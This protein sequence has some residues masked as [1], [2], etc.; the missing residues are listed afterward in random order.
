MTRGLPASLAALPV[1]LALAVPLGLVVGARV[2]AL[3][4]EG[5]AVQVDL[6][7]WQSV[8][9]PLR[10][11][12]SARPEAGRWG[13][14]ELLLFVPNRDETFRSAERTVVVP[15]AT[16]SSAVH[17]RLR[18]LQRVSDPLQ[19][20]LEVR[21]PGRL[22]PYPFWGASERLPLDKTN[23]RGTYR[24][25]D[26]TVA[27]PRLSLRAACGVAAR[28]Q[29]EAAN[30]QLV[31]DCVVLL[32]WRDTL[33]GAA[34]LNW[35]A[36]RAMASWTGV[37]IAGTP[38][39]VTKLDL[40]N[41]GL[42]GKLSGLVGELE[43]LAQLRLNGNNLTGRVPSKMAN[44][45]NLTH[46]YLAGNALSDCVP[47]WL[48][49]VAN[50]DLAAL[51]LPD[52]GEPGDI[53]HGGRT[54]T[55]GTYQVTG[56]EGDPPLVFDVPP[57]LQ[58]E[59]DGWVLQ[60]PG[61][62]GLLLRPPDSDSYIGLDVYEGGEWNRGIAEPADDARL[63]PLYDRVVESAWVDREYRTVV[64]VPTVTVA[65]EDEA[66]PRDPAAPEDWA[67]AEGLVAAAVEVVVWERDSSYFVSTRTPGRAWVTHNRE[68]S[69]P[70]GGNREWS[71]RVHFEAPSYTYRDASGGLYL[72]GSLQEPYVRLFRM[73]DG[74]IRGGVC[75]F[76]SPTSTDL[77]SCNHFD[78]DLYDFPWGGWKRSQAMAVSHWLPFPLLDREP[79]SYIVY[80][81][82][83][84]EVLA[85]V[86]SRLVAVM[87]WMDEDYDLTP[88]A[89]VR[90]GVTHGGAGCAL[91]A[92]W[93]SADKERCYNT[94]I[95]AHEYVHTLENDLHPACYAGTCWW[96]D[97]P[98][99]DPLPNWLQ[100]LYPATTG[101]YGTA[102]KNLTEG[103]AIEGVAVYFQFRYVEYDDDCGIGRQ[104]LGS[105]YES[106]RDQGRY[107]LGYGLVCELLDI[108]GVPPATLLASGTFEE[109]FGLAPD[110]FYE[111]VRE[112]IETRIEAREASAE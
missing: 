43:A 87:A 68:L 1:L 78:I 112:R 7:V 54:L 49:G 111:Q 59:V 40:A 101:T 16:S 3:Q 95:I 29:A 14:T 97:A 99:Q 73:S 104:W 6:R 106:G 84:N 50:H 75:Y 12:L 21:H 27:R 35:S 90:A 91:G 22:D 42:T 94:D 77:W 33:A 13:R 52:C 36:V 58:L 66:T 17:V 103:W 26:H 46:V 48:R 110:D 9:D 4:E 5:E 8:T 100:D 102:F 74:A 24:Y 57:G 44:L 39:R 108:T 62:I 72:K 19:V 86:E 53:S 56:E 51:R 61:E 105:I 60:G 31:E 63:N 67:S 96:G 85:T 65:V 107:R 82:A 37:T 81:D 23:E 89:L 15:G 34:T 80:G 64:P 18:V 93:F 69:L 25:S 83:P 98:R 30:S 20:Y 47:P 41:S 76:T 88:G 38:P 32:A 70:D 10:V 11:Y 2:D 92:M 55:V 109:L 28:V 45:S 71:R 79:D